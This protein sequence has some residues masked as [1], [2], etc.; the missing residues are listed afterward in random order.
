MSILIACKSDNAVYMGTDTRIIVN[1]YVKN[2]LCESNFKIQ[3]LENGLLVGVTAERYE[4]QTI[5]ANSEIFTLNR[6]G[7]L[8]RRHIVTSIIPKLHRLMEDEELLVEK[9]GE[10]PFM[11]GVILLAVND[12][13]Y[14]ITDKFDVIRH[15]DFQA[16]GPSS[17]YAQ[18]TLFNRNISDVNEKIIKALNVTSKYSNKAGGPYVLIDTKNLKYSVVGTKED[19][20][21]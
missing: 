3:K 20:K 6:N 14:E 11:K 1:D 21:W 18:A 4:R 9:E 15:E 2:D 16:V 7:T 13:L 12:V 19:I 8:N 5:F 17:N 10:T